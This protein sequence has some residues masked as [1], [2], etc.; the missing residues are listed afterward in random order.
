[1]VLGEMGTHRQKN[2]ICYVSHTMHKVYSKWI[3]DQTVLIKIIK[4]LKEHI[5]FNLC[6]L[7]LSCNLSDNKPKA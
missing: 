5:V 3:T 4:L 7:E 6:D 1:M 2:E